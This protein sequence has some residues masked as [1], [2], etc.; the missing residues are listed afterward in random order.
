[1][2]IR[3]PSRAFHVA[4]QP[5]AC[6]WWI[7][8]E[9]SPPKMPKLLWFLICCRLT[10]IWQLKGYSIHIFSCYQ[11]GI[12]LHVNDAASCEVLDRNDVFVC[13][14]QVL[15]GKITWNLLLIEFLQNMNAYSESSNLP[16]P[17]T[18]FI[19]PLDCRTLESLARTNT[20]HPWLSEPLWSGGCL[21][22]WTLLHN[23]NYPKCKYQQQCYT[24]Y[25]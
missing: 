3:T 22:K 20:V 9:P 17:S 12:L 10:T 24:L 19:L 21:N 8:Y 13:L 23:W 11:T 15:K 18:V 6:I 25:V 5:I 2:G 14:Q 16:S 7:M 1:M 4:K